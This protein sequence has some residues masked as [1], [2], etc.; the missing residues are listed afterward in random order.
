MPADAPG[1]PPRLA[2]GS[3]ALPARGLGYWDLLY[4]V[5]FSVAALLV[6]SV[7]CIAV[8]FGLGYF[9]GWEMDLDQ[10]SSK[11]SVAIAIQ[12]LASVLVLAFMY[13][14]I[15]VK[16]ELPFRRV[17]GWRP[18]EHRPFFYGASYCAA[19][20]LLA[21]TVGLASHVMSM[22]DQPTPFEDLLRDPSSLLL[23]AAFGIAIAPVVEELIFR[24][25]VFSVFERAHGRLAAVVITAGSFSLI[26]GPQYGWHWQILVLLFYVGIV[27]GAVRAKT[28]S[29]VPPTI[30][31]AAY[32]MTLLIGLLSA[33]QAPDGV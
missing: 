2:A 7:V 10:T 28:R 3:A 26:H 27:F 31:H 15:T 5:L 30:I 12:A 6:G 23:V 13:T 14:L 11:A 17:I 21:F 32:N 22:P 9:L 24:G 19:G 16:Y 25:F 4:L 1:E 8:Y 20:V 33:N 29:I 18:I